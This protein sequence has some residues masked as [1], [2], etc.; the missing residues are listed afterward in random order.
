MFSIRNIILH[1]G[2]FSVP[3]NVSNVKIWRLDPQ[4]VFIDPFCWKTSVFVGIFFKKIIH[5]ISAM[6]GDIT[7]FIQAA[8]CSISP[9]L[10]CF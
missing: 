4:S 3:E 10:L 8:Y 9:S 6:S 1:F 2:C 5:S 7:Y